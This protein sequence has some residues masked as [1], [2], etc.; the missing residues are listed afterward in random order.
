MFNLCYFDSGVNLQSFT[1]L[2]RFLHLEFFM[3]FCHHCSR[4]P[5]LYISSSKP[6]YHLGTACTTHKAMDSPRLAS[7]RLY[8]KPTEAIEK[9]L[10]G[11]LNQSQSKNC[12]H[13]CNKNEEST[14]IRMAGRAVAVAGM[15][16]SYPSAIHMMGLDISKGLLISV[17]EYL[18]SN[19]RRKRQEIPDHLSTI[20]Q[21]SFTHSFFSSGRGTGRVGLSHC[22]I[23]W[24][25][26]SWP[27][28]SRLRKQWEKTLV[29][30]SLTG[31]CNFP[32]NIIIHFKAQGDV[33]CAHIRTH[34]SHLLWRLWRSI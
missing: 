17:Q 28:C 15:S 24:S 13:T 7:P 12:K 16:W 20:F 9:T 18:E 26:C 10:Q 14:K 30:H 32:Y 5:S 25:C 31:P 11:D 8:P 33:F 19:R 29:W 34:T 21:S 2:L 6:R 3:E 23:Q 4:H 27:W 1:G 22:N